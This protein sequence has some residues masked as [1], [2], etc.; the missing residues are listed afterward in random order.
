MATAGSGNALPEGYELGEYKIKSVLGHGGFG[1]TY[2]AMDTKLSSL[3]AIKEYFPTSFSSRNQDSTIIPNS[4]PA[5]NHYKWGLEEFLKEARALAKF[6][7]PYIVRV[8]R[9]LEA[10]G[11]AYM[12]M[13]YERGESLEG[14][15]RKRGGYLDEK[16]MF[17]VFLP[18]L[19]G[20]QA[21]HKAGLLHLDIKPDNIYLRA[22]GKPMLIDFG[23][24]S[25]IAQEEGGEKKAVA[26]TPAYTAIENYPDK[27]EQ[28]PWSDLY[29]MGATLYRC[30]TG[31]QPVNTIDRFEKIGKG[32]PD[33][34]VAAVTM[35]R[36]LYTSYIRKC[37]DWAMQMDAKD[38]PQTAAALQNGLMGKGMKNEVDK[39]YDTNMIRSGYIGVAGIDET[40]I[41]KKRSIWVKMLGVMLFSSIMFI[42][43]L[44]S[45]MINEQQVHSALVIAY[46]K[47]RTFVKP[48]EDKIVTTFRI[49]RDRSVVET[50]TVAAEP[51]TEPAAAPVAT[52]FNPAKEVKHVFSGHIDKVQ[53]L[54]FLKKGK[55]LASASADGIIKL[56]D[57][58]SGKLFK[59][60]HTQQNRAGVIAASADGELLA[61]ISR[62]NMISIWSASTRA[63]VA[64]LAG[65]GNNI[66]QLAFST[67]G[68]HLASRS[69]DNTVIVWD[70][71]QKT[72]SHQFEFSHGVTSMAFSPNNRWLATGD[73]Q[74]EIAYWSVSRGTQL[75]KFKA[76]DGKVTSV[77]YSPDGKWLASAGPGGAMKL[78]SV[79]ITESDRAINGAPESLY[80]L[81]I[82][83]DNNWLLAASSESDVLMWDINSG[84]IA[85][86]LQTGQAAIKALALTADGKQ[87]AAPEGTKVKLWSSP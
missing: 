40:L 52:A 44:K 8:L 43:M 17:S 23:S 59:T 9:F 86:R 53:A 12:V 18:I 82:S 58:D 39:G 48:I 76:S 35:D 20:L 42:V 77:V 87:I 64:K 24:A 45:G 3:V 4:G 74:G 31:K 41:E 51:E 16:S 38:R 5:A 22:D 46:D 73:D 13:E 25:Q 15:L 57:T 62:Q 69:D 2:L 54:A 83:P 61:T 33:P 29:S 63:E 14:Y 65:H 21:V 72:I 32:Y 68:L 7:H 55:L 28:G 10:N 1:I 67:D 37:I 79:G 71:S 47:T 56:W 84:E 80:D 34:L 11:T 60:L 50:Q 27:G 6:K 66:N 78:W 30:I 85:H 75:A 26:L 81:V 70:V 19:S 49:K 36:P